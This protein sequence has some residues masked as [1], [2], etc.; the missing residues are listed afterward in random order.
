MSREIEQTFW[1]AEVGGH[2]PIHRNDAVGVV[3]FQQRSRGHHEMVHPRRGGLLQ[4][5]KAGDGLLPCDR[6]LQA[7]SAT[8]SGVLV[9][10]VPRD[11]FVIALQGT[12][13]AAHSS[14]CLIRGDDAPAR[15]R[16]GMP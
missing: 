11:A 7:E 2:D 6:A 15:Q 14:G 10:R 12:T 8:M 3:S 9:E 13:Y 1:I 5:P 4:L 16:Q